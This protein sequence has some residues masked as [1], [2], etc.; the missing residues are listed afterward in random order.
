[1]AA[2]KSTI[3]D[4]ITEEYY[5]I[6][7]E[8]LVSFPKYRPPLDFYRFREQIATLEPYS[9]KGQRLSNQQVEEL[10]TLCEN[11]LLFVSRSDHPVYSTH[12]CKQLDLVLVDANL[13]EA[14]IADIFIQAFHM[15]LE[16]FFEQP[17]QVVFDALYRDIMVLTEYLSQDMYRIRALMRRLQT[18]HSLV[19]H[20][21]NCGVVGL[22]L[23]LTWRKGDLK[24]RELDRGAM[25]AFLHDMGMCKIPS[26][27]ITKT[28]PLTQEERAKINAHPGA[29]LKLAEKLGLAYD[30]M[31]QGISEH[32]ERLDGSGYPR[33]LSESE[34]SNMGKLIAVADSFCA[35]IT[36]RPYAS[37]M[38]P[39]DAAKALLDDAR[40]YDQRFSKMLHTAYAAGDL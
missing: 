10:A 32:H 27:I 8:I 20:S 12:I 17:V 5:Q 31:K 16:A 6:S 2:V 7:Q 9:R 35:M 4:N 15:R 11:G 37:A 39:K 13:R 21:V 3:P 18:K 22:W 25:A 26:F 36:D 33:R 38:T 23:L 34:M 29:G 14:E 24:R 1:M 30:E 19:T 40:R 28:L